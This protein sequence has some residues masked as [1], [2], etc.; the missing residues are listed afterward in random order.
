MHALERKGVEGG[1]HALPNSPVI[2]FNLWHV[3]IPRGAVELDPILEK[4]I[5][6]AF[7]FMITTTFQHLEALSTVEF[8]GRP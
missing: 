8:E 6:D 7:E 2:S 4:T 1:L 3:F 5:T